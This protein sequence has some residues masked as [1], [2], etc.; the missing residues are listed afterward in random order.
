MINREG[1]KP[2]P[3]YLSR[4]DSRKSKVKQRLCQVLLCLGGLEEIV[5][6][7]IKLL[8]V[9]T[10]ATMAMTPYPCYR[11]ISPWGTTATKELAC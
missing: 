2:M 3:R 6:I 4:G 9:V 5:N 7:V 11:D 1:V 10:T 8:I